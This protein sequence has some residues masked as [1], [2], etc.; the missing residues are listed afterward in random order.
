MK[1]ADGYTLMHEHI[2]IDLSSVKNDSDCHLDCIDETIKEFK[3]LYE[4]GVRNIVEVTNLGM[5]RNLEIIEKVEKATGIQ[6]IK[7]T[8]CY[9]E[10]FIPEKYLNMGSEQLA[11]VM[12]QEIENGFDDFDDKA[13][14]IGEIGTSKD[15]WKESERRLFDAAILAHKKTGK[16]IYTH[17]TLSTL[18]KQQAEYLVSNGVDPKKVVIGHVD[19]SDDFDYILSVLETGVFVGFDTIGKENYLPDAKRIQYLL[20]LEKLGKINQIV[21]SEDLTRKSHLKYKGGIGYA[22]LFETFIPRLKEAGIKETSIN[23]MLI[24]NPRIILEDE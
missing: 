14:M 15:E 13:N 9:K 8:G 12:I 18:A 5:G 4:Y 11:D 1:L 22:Y 20:Q 16:P 10:P 21:L 6:I 2:H 24:H 7:S 23:Q 19:L 3:K 17:T